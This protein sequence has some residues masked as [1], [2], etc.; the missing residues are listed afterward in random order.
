MRDLLG[1]EDIAFQ[2]DP[3]GAM[4]SLPPFALQNTY[5]GDRT[6]HAEYDVRQIRLWSVPDHY[7]NLKLLQVYLH[8]ISER[9]R[10]CPLPKIGKVSHQHFGQSNNLIYALPTSSHGSLCPATPIFAKNRSPVRF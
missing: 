3:Q 2:E 7:S 8:I 5:C 9:Q 10:A 1:P 6:G 4:F